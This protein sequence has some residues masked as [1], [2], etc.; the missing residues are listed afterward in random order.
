MASLHLSFR[1]KVKALDISVII[2]ITMIS[3]IGLA[4]LYSAGGGSFEPWASKQMFRFAVGFAAMMA[5]ALIDL[6]FWRTFSYFFYFVTFALLLFVEFK[7]HIGMGAQRWIDL[8]VF[9]LQP[10]EL[11]KISLI[12]ALANYFHTATGYEISKLKTYIIPILL[13]ALPSVLMLRQPDLGTML[14]L[15]ATGASI[16]FVVGIRYWKVLS[17]VGLFAVSLPLIWNH[18]HDYQKKRV[19][20]FLNPDTDKLGSGY[21]ILQSKIAIGSGGFWGKGYLAGSQSQLNFLPEKQT[22]FIFAMFCEEFGVFGGIVLLAL[23]TFLIIYGYRVTLENKNLFGRLVGLGLT[24]LFFL[25]VFVNIAMVMEIL[26]VVGIPLPFMS[27]GGTSMLTLMMCF[28][29]LMSASL[30]RNARFGRSY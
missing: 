8:Y 2:V 11:M 22:D 14:I 13:I 19:L 23:Y 20:T 18:L 3:A 7:G 6:R 24:T 27:Y 25:S 21:H 9:H 4:I 17:V 29:L 1:E 12:L 15:A 10:S 30:Y 5:I 26:P 28:G 16:V